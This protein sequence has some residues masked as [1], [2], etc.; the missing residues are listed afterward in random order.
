MIQ[1]VPMDFLVAKTPYYLGVHSHTKYAIPPSIPATT[2]NW[3][4]SQNAILK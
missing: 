3:F 2:N 4:N 1:L